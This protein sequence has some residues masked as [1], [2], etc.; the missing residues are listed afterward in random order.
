VELQ[1]IAAKCMHTTTYVKKNNTVKYALK[2]FP[3]QGSNSLNFCRNV[4]ERA[5]SQQAFDFVPR[6]FL[7]MPK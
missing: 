2:I 3:I 6:L 7:G 4:K 5:Y 1:K